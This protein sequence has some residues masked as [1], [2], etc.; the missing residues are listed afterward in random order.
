M[1]TFTAR[2]WLENFRMGQ[3]TFMYLCSLSPTLQRADTIMRSAISVE[4]RIAI[5]LWCL[6]TPA[7]YRTIAHLFGMARSTV[8]K[9]V[10]ETC[11]SIV[12]VLK[13]Q[14]IKFPQGEHLK[15]VVDGFQTK[16]GAP[17]CVGAIDGS[18][19]PIT[20]PR[21]CHTDY[22]N[23]KGY[24]SI[25]LQGLV[26]HNYIFL[27]VYIGWPGSVHDAR[28]FSHSSLYTKLCWTITAI[29]HYHNF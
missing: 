28:V 18:H 6:A 17:Q 24:Y 13:S 4:R 15:K 8:C 19:I 29:K 21:E 2:D 3:D 5:T 10:H 20:G 27:D 9:I 1:E 16:W 25:I 22:F 14:Y 12:T 23:R 11:Q 7:E 26:D